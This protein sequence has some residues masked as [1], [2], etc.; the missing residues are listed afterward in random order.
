[1]K[2]TS[3]RVLTAIFCDDI[4]HEVGNKMSFMGC[5]QNELFVPTAPIA[6]AKLCVYVTLL[7]PIA[8]PVRSLRFRVL[9]DDD[10]ELARVEIPDEA[11]TNMAVVSE[12]AATRTSVSAAMMFSPFTIEK[13]SVLRV[14]ADTDEGEVWFLGGIYKGK[15]E[16]PTVMNGLGVTIVSTPQ[17]VMTDRKARATGIG[18]EILCYVA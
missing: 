15:A 5:Y 13:G 1:M 10:R 8:R 11:F 4:R 6:L 12:G 7:T 17:G 14:L 3:D 9:M 16:I 2:A 18:G